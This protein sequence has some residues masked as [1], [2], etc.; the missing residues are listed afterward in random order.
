MFNLIQ[1]LVAQRRW[2]TATFGPG[3][4]TSGVLDHI[5]KELDEIAGAPNDLDEWIDVIILACD[6]AWRSG[7]SPEKIVAA[8]QR[9]FAENVA[10]QWPDWRTQPADKAIEHVR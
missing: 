5:R 4:R 1:H 7:H 10:R 6:G 8:L 9:K 2:S 3:T